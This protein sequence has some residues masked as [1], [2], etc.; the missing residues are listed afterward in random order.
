M[1]DAQEPAT[2]AQQNA[3]QIQVIA[4]YIR[5]FSFENPN[6]PESIV[7][8]WG[9]PDTNIQVFLRH[10]QM[11]DD[12][13]ECTVNFRVEAKKKGE[14]K[15]AFIIDLSYGALVVL[16]NIPAEHHQ[17]AIFVEVPKLLYP[18][19]REI[20]ASAT[21][22]GGY[23]PLYLAPISFEAIYVNELK[24]QKEAQTAQAGAA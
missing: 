21:A 18:F 13:Y 9:A 6:A 5:D 17:P 15:V 1:T 3:P 10:Q 24:R 4:Q 12:A 23:P 19:A 8:G 14:N 7:G 11:K 2:D 16:K 22:Q 20:V